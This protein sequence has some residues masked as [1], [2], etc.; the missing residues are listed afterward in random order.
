LASASIAQVHTARMD[1]AD[2][3][4]KVQRPGIGVRIAA[5]MRIMKFVARQSERFV[6]DAELVN[7]VGIVEDFEETLR[8]ELD[9]RKE[10]ENLAQFNDIMAEL[11]HKDVR[12]PRPLK[13]TPRVL[14]MERFHGVRVD[15][16]EAIAKREVNIE[17]RLIAGMRAWFQSVLFYGFFHGHVHAGNLMLLDNNAVGFNDRQRAMVT[18]YIVAF[19]TGDYRTL[20]RVITEMG[21]V[22]HQ[23]D[24]DGFAKDLEKTYSP[25]LKLS[26][27]DINYGE[28]LPKIQQV[29][30]R[31]RMRMP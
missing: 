7:P 2:V 23:I 16:V 3:V 5:D 26:F 10:A 29:A 27:Q 31:H 21:S 4:V 13:A 18:D 24:Q 12:A 28:M 22:H 30:S 1:G 9:F 14:V 8:E 20:A 17:E 25:L 19:A 6:R 11:G 15:N